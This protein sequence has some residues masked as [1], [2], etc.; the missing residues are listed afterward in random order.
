M[1]NAQN[2]ESPITGN[3]LLYKNPEPLS[4]E[5]HK[6]LGLKNIARPFGFVETTHV[7]PLTVQEFGM[8]AGSMPIIFAPDGK[9]PLAVLS[10]RAG[11]NL[12]V[13]G[14][15]NWELDGYIPAFIRRYP[16][17]FAADPQ[18]DNFVV[19]ID[20]KAEMI[21][22][23]PDLP[24]FADD[25]PTAYTNNAMEFLQDFERQRRSTE[26]FMNI[27]TA[28]DLLEEKTVTFTP[29]NGDG[30]PAEPLKVADYIGISEEKLNA[31][32]AAKL[33]ELKQKGCL[34]A[35]YA[36]LVSLL[37]WQ[38]MVQR[39]LRNAPQSPEIANA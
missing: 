16:F 11:D 7:V 27:I 31:L 3:V 39:T 15:G 23:N 2:G 10:A 37:Q 4:L 34:G 24:L 8:A 22:E 5:A 6:Q 32:P 25:K 36:H 1:S 35:I 21:G 38:K 18:G 13:D 12:F 19:C 9:T 26:E 29:T 20:T 33:L 30:S 28:M 14:D 17:V